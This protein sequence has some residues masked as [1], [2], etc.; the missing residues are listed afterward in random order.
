MESRKNIITNRIKSFFSSDFN[1]NVFALAFGTSIAQFITYASYPIVSRLYTPQEFGIFGLFTSIAGMI[2]LISTGRYELAIIL[3]SSDKK[4]FH[5][6]VLSFLINSFISSFVLIILFALA[7]FN[8]K[9]QGDYQAL[10]SVIFLIPLYILLSGA[11]NI[12][13]N[14]YLRNK[15]FRLISISKVLMSLINNGLVIVVGLLSIKLWGLFIGFFVSATMVVVYFVYN[16]FEVYKQNKLEI[17]R[18][19]ISKVAKQYIDFPKANTLHA[20]SDLFQSQGLVYFVAI[21]YSASTVGLYTFA[22]RVLYA[23][24]MLL[25]SSFTQVFYQKASEMYNAKQNLSVLLQTTV[26]KV[27]A[28]SMPIMLILMLFADELFALIFSEQWRDSGVYARILAPWICIDFVRYTIAQ[29]PLILGKVK[30][31][32]FWSL[33]G[34]VLIV[35]VML[36]SHIVGLDVLKSFMLL[37][38]VM[39]LYVIFQIIWIFKITHYANSR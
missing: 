4:A 23:P 8:L 1:K 15:K 30:Q 10:N 21:I 13:Q 27:F 26:L 34:N 18:D 35:M 7:I 19:N 12:F 25:V 29:M 6:V 20:L 38:L 9:L 5:L 24:M 33:S 11:N 37:S 17:G 16:F 2:T 36:F 31:V 14:Y 28:F 3:P 22:M 32:L 39:T